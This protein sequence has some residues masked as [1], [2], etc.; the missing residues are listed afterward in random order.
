[1]NIIII[2]IIYTICITLMYL[3][4]KNNSNI[5]SR[6]IIPILVTLQ[7]K[8][9]FG[10]WDKG[11][12]YTHMDILYWCSLLTLSYLSVRFGEIYLVGSK[13]TKFTKYIQNKL[14]N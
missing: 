7:I 11:Y 14:T 10:D 1:M 12:R 2:S 3:F 9:I 8:Y 6:Y 4:F 5:S 13:F